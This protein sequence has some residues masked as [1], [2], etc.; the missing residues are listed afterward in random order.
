[1][2]SLLIRDKS[3]ILNQIKSNRN[4]SDSTIKLIDQTY[5]IYN[6]KPHFVYH[7]P[8][9]ICFNLQTILRPWPPQHITSL[10][11]NW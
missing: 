11:P 6:L 2:K 4:F 3:L 10:V 5:K 9:Q 7:L 1:M 8:L